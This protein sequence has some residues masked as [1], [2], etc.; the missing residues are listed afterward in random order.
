MKV[1]F[2]L[3]RFTNGEQ[4]ED[5]SIS[6]LSRSQWP[7]GLRRNFAAARLLGWR[8]RIPLRARM[9]V[10]HAVCSVDSGLC[11]EIIT[12]SEELYRVCVFVSFT[13]L[14][15]RRPKSDLRLAPQNVNGHLV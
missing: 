8:V 7:C 1:N 11:D 4:S 6:H 5:L 12:H 14:K 15:K 3:E 2:W 13:K 10:A 9:F